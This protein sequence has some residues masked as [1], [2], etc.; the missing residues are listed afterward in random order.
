VTIAGL[1]SVWTNNPYAIQLVASTDTGMVI[2]NAFISSVTSTQSV[3]YDATNLT[4]FNGI[5]G[6][7]STMSGP[8]TN[9]SI[10][11]NGAPATFGKAGSPPVGYA[12]ASTIAGFIVTDKPVV[13]MSP[14][15]VLAFGGDTP[16]V[17]SASAV[18]VPPLSYQWRRNGQ[19]IPGATLLSLTN[20]TVTPAIAGSY[21]L[22]V[23]N[24]YGRAT[25]SV[26]ILAVDQITV[27]VGN[28]YVV[29]SNTNGTSHDGLNSGANWLAAS[30]DSVP[31]TRNGVMQFAS[32]SPS[33]IVVSG[34]TNFDATAGTVTFWMR[35][36]GVA[37]PGGNPAMLFDRAG[38]DGLQIVLNP[39]GTV[40]AQ[41]ASTPSA[42]I[43]GSNVA[44]N[45]WHHIAVVFDQP[46]MLMGIYVDGALFYEYN[47][48]PVWQWQPGQEIELGLS[49]TATWQA[50]D[51]LLDDVRFYNQ[52][53]TDADI[54][55]VY[56]TGALAKPG[57][58][59]MQL[60]FDTAPVNGISLQWQCPDAVLQSADSAQ[61][62]YSDLPAARSPYPA[63]AVKAMKFYRYHGHTPAPVI[64][65]P[66]L[67]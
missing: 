44:D 25:S 23:T 27:T 60:N 17:L 10:S 50:Y 12:I 64:S 67:M 35:S 41:P 30:T 6:G 48:M 21:D 59:V 32:A 43:A 58:L 4:Y 1:R 61:G 49:H 55:Y 9:D 36:A 15:S 57:A 8:W 24:L 46:G 29:D 53:L 19:P 5:M 26:A 39:D 31:V 33:Q 2:T 52:V 40:Q 56:S 18:G 38:S 62:P 34:Q 65:N 20:T 28:N 45:K 16:V 66:Y 51:G 22:L 42:S 3:T 13:S 63:A 54:A 11:I 14:N 47:L 7:L 37:D